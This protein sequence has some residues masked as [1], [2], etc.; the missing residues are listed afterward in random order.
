M[1]VL[2]WIASLLLI[3]F[4]AT[5]QEK[6][7]PG[8][9]PP[10]KGGGPAI[11]RPGAVQPARVGNQFGPGLL[12]IGL[13]PAKPGEPMTLHPALMKLP[14]AKQEQLRKLHAEALKSME[15]LVTDLRGKRQGLGEAL[16]KYPVDKTGLSNQQEAAEKVQTQLFQ[17]HLNTLVEAQ[18][19]VDKETWEAVMQGPPMGRSRQ[20]PPGAKGP[21]LDPGRPGAPGP[22]GSAPPP[23]TPA[24]GPRPPA[25]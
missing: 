3:A 25:K 10:G 1:K 17:L 9:A 2:F 14:A 18:K 22:Q 6:G 20:M 5:A 13:I 24:P 21:M 19:V 15:G 23:G 16:R 11:V 7:G 4:A 12:G 8:A